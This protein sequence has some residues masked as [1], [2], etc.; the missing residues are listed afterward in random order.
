MRVAE[1]RESNRIIAQCVDWL[2]QH[3]GPVL[4][5]QAKVVPPTRERSKTH[6]EEMIHQFKHFSEGYCVPEGEVYASVEHPKGELGVFMVSDGANK[7][8]RVKIRAAGYPHLQALNELCQGHMISDVVIILAS[9][10][11]VFGEIDR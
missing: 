6:M 4:A 11:I 5:Q 2:R 7:P 3:P 9:M 1:M 8:Y 10:D